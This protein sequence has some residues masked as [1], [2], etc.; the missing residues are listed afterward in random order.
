MAHYQITTAE[1]GKCLERLVED[2]YDANGNI[3][4][5]V[6]GP[7]QPCQKRHVG[8]GAKGTRTTVARS[9]NIPQPMMSVQQK[10]VERINILMISVIAIFTALIIFNL[11]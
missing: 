7:W 2:V 11:K 1:S 6:L 8:I 5:N 10:E 4:T 9:G 3:V